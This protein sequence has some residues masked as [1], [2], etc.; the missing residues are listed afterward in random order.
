MSASLL[1]AAL[2]SEDSHSD[3][4][5]EYGHGPLK[6]LQPIDQASSHTGDG[7]DLLHGTSAISHGK[8]SEPKPTGR[9]RKA[10]ASE[11]SGASSKS[12]KGE[13]HFRQAPPNDGK[14]EC[15]FVQGECIPLWPQY[16]SRSCEGHFLRVG[17]REA[18]VLKILAM[19]KRNLSRVD[20]AV[21]HDE[22]KM[23]NKEGR[24]L[25]AEVC[26]DLLSK[27]QQAIALAKKQKIKSENGSFPEVL[28]LDI[29][30]CEVQASTRARNFHIL[31]AHNASRFVQSVFLG[32]IANHIGANVKAISHAESKCLEGMGWQHLY[33]R[34]AVREKIHWMP[35][36][37]A[38]GLRFSGTPGADK[39][40]CQDHSLSLAVDKNLS[41]DRFV[42]ARRQAFDAA[43]R[44]WNAVD[45]SGRQRIKADVGLGMKLVLQ[46]ISHEEED[47]EFAGSD[48]ENVSDAA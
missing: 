47:A 3:S 35:D 39:R 12:L 42:L 21:G 33:T 7:K 1:A 14:L 19:S 16:L 44:V 41:G 5:R 23:S 32:A 29:E 13:G 48:D 27:L 11:S 43:C 28:P 6:T 10:H 37:L 40:Y 20:D 17:P 2:G 22:S 38:W 9:K 8:Y 15:V 45:T 24:K 36:K 34:N 26:R 18:W 31:A 30:G 4:D 46:A 25:A